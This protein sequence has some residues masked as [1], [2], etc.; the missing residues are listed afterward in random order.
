M[1]Y[2]SAPPDIVTTRPAATIR[3]RRMRVSIT[4]SGSSAKLIKML[5][6]MGMKASCA[7]CRRYIVAANARIVRATLRTLT[8]VSCSVGGTSARA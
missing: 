6:T 7:Q 8:C 4:T 2:T 1:P 3:G 5:R